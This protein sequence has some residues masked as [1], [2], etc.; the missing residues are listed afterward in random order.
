MVSSKILKRVTRSTKC[1]TK[2]SRLTKTRFLS[3]WRNLLTQRSTSS[4]VK[5]TKRRSF[6]C[7]RQKVCWKLLV[8]MVVPETNTSPSSRTIIWLCVSKS[9]TNINLIRFRLGML[10]ECIIY[11]KG[12]IQQI[13]D[14]KFYKSKRLSMRSRRL[15]QE[16]K[17]K[18]Q[19]CAIMS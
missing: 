1:T 7:R 13:S 3:F 11:L 6:Y 19:L 8:S 15:R 18:L 5:T 9:K 2:K 4:H 17:L 10:E 12:S 14:E 16:C